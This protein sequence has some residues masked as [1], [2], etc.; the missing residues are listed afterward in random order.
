MPIAPSGDARYGVS[1]STF[2]DGDFDPNRLISGPRVVIE[3]IVR[4]WLTPRGSLLTA[5]DAGID[6]REW[7][8]A[9]MEPGGDYARRHQL[10]AEAMR[11]QRVA[12][13]DVELA[14]D[15]ATE[16]LTI[17][18]TVSLVGANTP[19]DF[20]LHVTRARTDLVFQEAA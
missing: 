10:I 9:T 4:G 17:S 16:R 3:S 8:G 6:V 19:F 20:V 18:A 1:L 12:D 14:F 7:I 2:V 13:I 11:D 15:Q 5:P